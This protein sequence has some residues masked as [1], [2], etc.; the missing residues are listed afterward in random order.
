[1]LPSGQL[2]KLELHT[3]RKR[4]LVKILN[5]SGPNIEPGRTSVIT[6]S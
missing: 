6:F 2:L 4:S 3:K 1:M 5:K